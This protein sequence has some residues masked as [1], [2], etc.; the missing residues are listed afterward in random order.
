MNDTRAPISWI[1]TM[2]RKQATLYRGTVT[3]H[4]RV[5]LDA[6]SNVTEVWEELQHGRPSPRTGK[7]GH[8]YAS[9]G[10][11][12]DARLHRFAKEIA[13]WLEKELDAHGVD[14]AHVFASRRLLGDFRKLVGPP[15]E[16]RMRLEAL[17]LAHLPLGELAEHEAVVGVVRETVA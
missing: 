9:Q 6:V 17:D 4:E 1:V 2:D 8:S 16:K 10:H 7:N 13:G 14:T 3:P 5:H 12:E 15:F 11:E